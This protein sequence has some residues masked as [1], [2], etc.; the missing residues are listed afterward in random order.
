MAQLM[1]FFL[2]IGVVVPPVLGVLLLAGC[3]AATTPGVNI[4]AAGSLATVPA[5]GRT[6][7]D[8]L[9]SL[10]SGRDCSLVR[11]EKG[12]SYC[13]PDAPPWEA[14]PF[15]TRSLGVVDCWRNP[16]AFGMKMTG[17]ADGPT[18]TA[19]QEAYRTRSWPDW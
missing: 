10:V 9:I 4:A 13:R 1:R 6:A 11:M 12:E 17:V 18:P 3:G 19:Q 2:E 15:C 7:P 8:A 16:E 5:L 14:A